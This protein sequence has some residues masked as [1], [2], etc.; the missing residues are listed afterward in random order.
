MD[1]FRTL[2]IPASQTTLARA[3]AGS[4]G[5]GGAGMWTTPL[6]TNGAEPATHYISSGYLPEEFAFL[7]PLQ[8]WKQNEQ[9]NWVLVSS[10]PG[11]PAGVYEAATEQG[12]SCTQAEVE[13]LFA[14]AD[15]SAQEPFVA[16]K[17]LALTIVHPPFER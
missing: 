17:R 15:V 16:M 9:G 5:T 11:D 4:F 1:V 6:S 13:G 8:D 3:I 2:V 10:E 7:A 12:V 14:A